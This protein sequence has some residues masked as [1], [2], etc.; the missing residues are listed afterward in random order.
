MARN[1]NSKQTETRIVSLHAGYDHQGKVVDGYVARPAGRGTHPAVVVISGM[2]GL[3]A[4]QREITRVFARAG[5][6]TLSPDIF[7]GYS[8]PNQAAALLAK[9][10]LDVDQTIEHV[11]AGADFLRQLPWVEDDAKIGVIGF[12]LGGGLALLALARSGQFD[13]GVIYYQSLF[14]DPSELEHINAKM[15]CHYGTNDKSTPDEEV[16]RFRAVLDAHGKEYEACFYEGAGHSFL[17]PRTQTGT[18]SANAAAA[19][20]SLERTF[21]FLHAELSAAHEEPEAAASDVPLHLG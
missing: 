1:G 5:F 8:A 16:E 3:N 4:F 7:D 19:T 18:A 20:E 21:A 11:T 15:L 2:S 13:A 10:S 12:C 6:V 14:P 9:N 17:N